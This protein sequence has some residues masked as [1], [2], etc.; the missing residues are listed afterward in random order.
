MKVKQIEWSEERPSNAQIP[1]NHVIG[2]TP[3]GNFEITWKS[4]KESP[5]FN[6]EHTV[7]GYISD[8]ISLDDAKKDAQ[9]YFEKT[10]LDCLGS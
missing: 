1:Y 6:V 8:H 2:K 3:L 10:V 5:S 9:D 4:W 7:F